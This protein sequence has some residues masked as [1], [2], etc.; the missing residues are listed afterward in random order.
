MH[1]LN[2]YLVTV[3]ECRCFAAAMVTRYI[4]KTAVGISVIVVVE[5]RSFVLQEPCQNVTDFRS[6]FRHILYLDRLLF[7]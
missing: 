5:L 2:S 1:E 3:F 4:Y 7:N 6:T